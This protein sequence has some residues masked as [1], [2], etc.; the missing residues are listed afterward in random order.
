MSITV[1]ERIS[2][3]G[4]MQAPARPD[5]EPAAGSATAGGA[6]HTATRP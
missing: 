5:E 4:V 3:N 6:C 1:I 2:L